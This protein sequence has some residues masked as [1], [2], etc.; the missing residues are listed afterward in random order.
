MYF[1][2]WF[3]WLRL[4]F[5]GMEPEHRRIYGEGHAPQD[6]RSRPLPCWIIV[7]QQLQITQ[8]R[9]TQNGPQNAPNMQLENQ[10]L[11]KMSGEGHC[12]LFRPLPQLGGVMP[13]LIPTPY[14]IVACGAS[15]MALSTLNLPPTSQGF[16]ANSAKARQKLESLYA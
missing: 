4:R 15:A 12:P 13:P 16:K 10:K 6:A 3:N 8:T 14:S 11:T 1:W 9:R 5:A 7:F 2:F